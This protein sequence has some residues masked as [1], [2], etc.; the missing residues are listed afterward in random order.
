[1]TDI[2]AFDFDGTLLDSRARHEIVM[3]DVLRANG[4]DMDVSG[5]VEF[6]RAGANNVDFM[7]SRGM[8]AAAARRIQSQWVARIERDEYLQHDVLY[9]DAIKMLDDYGARGDLILITARANAAGLQS[10]IDKFNLRGRFRDIYVVAPGPSASPAKAEILSRV[11]AV[12]MIGDTA[13]DADAAKTA[14]TK[15]VFHE[16]GFHNKKTAKGI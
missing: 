13:S 5:L 15:F 3:S 11:H 7:V 14:G 4:I 2:I 16:N 6:K 1:M 9:P 12:C 8:D 10:Q